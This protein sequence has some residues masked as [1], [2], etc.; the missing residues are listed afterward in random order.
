MTG[1]NYTMLQKETPASR[2]KVVGLAV[3]MLIPVTVWFLSTLMLSL[4]VLKMNLWPAI[5]VAL[6]CMTL[7][8]LMEK[9]IVMS[10]GGSWMAVFRILIGFILASLGSLTLDEVLFDGDISRSVK[11]LRVMDGIAASDSART[12]FERM[13]G[14]AELDSRIHAAQSAYEAAEASVIQEAN[15]TYGTGKRGVG[16]ITAL[17][18]RKAQQRQRDLDALMAQKAVLDSAKSRYVETARQHAEAS[19]TEHGLLIRIKAL[20][21]LVKSDAWMM[22]TYLLFTGLMLLVEFMVVIFKMSWPMTNYERRIDMIE[23]IGERRMA[24]LMSEG[25]PVYDP[26]RTGQEVKETRRFLDRGVSIF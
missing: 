9:L 8:F 1:D 25:S 13:N 17:K 5:L 16:K 6:C 3:A 7:I 11:R 22:I 2:R 26:T 23:R 14:Y 12:E 19:F 18:D 21:D 10:K 24:M 20:A 4:H 15:G